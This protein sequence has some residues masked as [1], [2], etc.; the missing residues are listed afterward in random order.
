MSFE[1]PTLATLIERA[2]TDIELR[3]TGASA[4]LRRSV[5]TALAYAV[6]G[7]AHGL[8]GHLYYVSKQLLPDS[9]DADT[10]YRWASIL[11]ITPTSPVA[12][13]GPI[14]ITGADETSIP[15][16]TIW[17]RADGV[18]FRTTDVAAIV[19]TDATVT[20]EA[21]VPGSDGNTDQDTWLTICTPIAGID[22]RALVVAD[23]IVD[24]VDAESTVALRTRVYARLQTPPTGGGPGDYVRWA[25][26]VAGVTRAWE[27][28]NQL[29]IGTVQLLFA[30]DG[31]MSPSPSEAK[32]IEVQAYI[33]ARAPVTAD[34][35]VSAPTD[36]QVDFELSVVPDTTAVRDAIEAELGALILR[37]GSAVGCTLDL[38]RINEAI[39]LAAGETSHILTNPVANQTY[40]IGELPTLGDV[41]FT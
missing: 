8:H 1:R 38:S 13:V 25:K 39:S 31:E 40:A 33:D 35:T 32:V 21:V 28:P 3:L 11:G 24:G 10:I 17:T 26:E 7:L 34:V 2:M 15:A 36:V 16:G 20:V 6:A 5:E 30:T 37:E 14:L 12:A 18:E 41:V 9:D 27:L 4:R 29:G 23:S 22:S 19:G